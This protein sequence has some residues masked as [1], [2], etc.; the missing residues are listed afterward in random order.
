M[1]RGRTSAREEH[2]LYWNTWPSSLCE[3]CR[4]RHSVS[5]LSRSCFHAALSSEDVPQSRTHGGDTRFQVIRAVVDQVCSHLRYEND[6]IS[7]AYKRC[8]T[9]TNKLTWQADAVLC[10]CVHV[11]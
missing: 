4:A 9:V 8:G 10:F 2:G 6:F 7:L 3:V 1:R 5:S 11:W